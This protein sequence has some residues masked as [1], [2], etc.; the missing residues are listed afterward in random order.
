MLVLL[1]AMPMISVYF[2]AMKLS[3]AKQ[4]FGLPE[5]SARS[6]LVLSLVVLFATLTFA[7]RARRR[8]VLVAASMGLCL[9]AAG[10]RQSTDLDEVRKLADSAA[11]AQLSYDAVVADFTASC[12][13]RTAWT[14]AST[15]ELSAYNHQTVNFSKLEPP[16]GLDPHNVV[17]TMT[18]NDWDTLLLTYYVNLGLIAG[19]VPGAD[20]FGLRAFATTLDSDKE[21]AKDAAISARVTDVSGLADKAITAMFSL[22]RQDDIAKY[23]APGGPVTH[24]FCE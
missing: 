20:Q 18:W 5:G 13:R 16:C 17:A 7:K 2:A 9:F 23:A 21:V 22:R 11:A 14:N 8:K 15:I 19:R 24:S 6:V 3:D 12:D 1:I 4:A 10:C